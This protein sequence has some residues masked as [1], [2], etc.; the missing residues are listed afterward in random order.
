MKVKDL[1]G[2]HQL[3]APVAGQP[4]AG[5]TDEFV[6]GV[7]PFRGKVVG[8]YFVPSAAITGHTTNKMTLTLKNRGQAGAGTTAV[9]ALEFANGVDGV[10]HDAKAIT[11][12]ATAS[13]LELAEGDVLSFD[14]AVAGSGLA[15]PD[16]LVVV[17]LQAR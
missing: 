14:K 8:C 12:S 5:T 15:M 11:L 16:G 6:V 7:A 3:A 10:A 9:A 17:E 1:Q 4:T 13:E 2:V